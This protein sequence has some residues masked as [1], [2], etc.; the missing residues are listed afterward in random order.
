M[1]EIRSALNEY[2]HYFEGYSDNIPV[3][4]STLDGQYQGVIYFD[5]K[6]EIAMLVTKY[7]FIFLGGN[8]ESE[9]AESI[10]DDL[11]FNEL[12][13]RQNKKEIVVFG[14]NEKWNA[15]LSKVFQGH[16]GV[17]D[18]RKVFRLNREKF[19]ELCEKE[20]P[21]DVQ[22]IVKYEHENAATIDYPVSRIYVNGLNV[23]FCS[24]FMLGKGHAE[25]DVATDEG[26]R[27]KGYAKLAAIALMKE[28]IKRGIEPD[29]CTWPYRFESQALAKSIGFELAKEIA[30][31]I[32]LEEFGLV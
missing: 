2:S 7:D 11:I 5:D 24:A 4:Y 3:I 12:V 25:I 31:H 9:K 32:W 19:N 28:L 15:V 21:D 10:I 23:S 27:Q 13:K 26:F 22:V 14:Q 30:A 20:I 1:K 6:E 17:C 18:L 29:W 8:I 16:H